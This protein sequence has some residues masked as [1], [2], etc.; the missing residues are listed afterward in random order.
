MQV[1]FLQPPVTQPGL[2][3]KVYRVLTTDPC[4][5]TVSRSFFEKASSDDP[6]DI[7]SNYP[8]WFIQY[9]LDDPKIVNQDAGIGF[10]RQYH[11]HST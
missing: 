11:E 9:G 5:V 4:N 3:K 1:N 6:A 2:F 10:L 7:D 8:A